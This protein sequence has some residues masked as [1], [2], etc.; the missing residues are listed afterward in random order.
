MARVLGIGG[1]FCRSEDPAATQ[2][3]YVENLGLPK[4]AQGYVVLPWTREAPGLNAATVWAPFAADTG[5]FDAP[6]AKQPSEF[7]INYVVDDLDGMRAQ[8]EA[9]GVT[10]LPNVQ[11]MEGIGR[12]GWAIDGD[13]RRFEL[14]EP[15]RS[16]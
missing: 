8:L 5:Y 1:V 15:E 13:G 6:G 7:M 16:D 2:E 14:W 11:E 9:K 3:W 4:D 10:V 12:F